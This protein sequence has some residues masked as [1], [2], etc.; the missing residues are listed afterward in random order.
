MV[1]FNND[2]TV[3]TPAID[4]V[5]VLVLQARN[6]VFEALE[7]VNKQEG[8]G[9]EPDLSMFRARVCTWF[10]EQQAYFKRVMPPKEYDDVELELFKANY[11]KERAL[12]IISRF[13][14]LVDKL[15]L[16]KLDNRLYYDTTNAEADNVSHGL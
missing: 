1:D 3:G 5:R 13:N 11:S 8:D 14:E 15:K 16:T 12:R 9:T 10:F 6:N 4:I 2:V 7:F